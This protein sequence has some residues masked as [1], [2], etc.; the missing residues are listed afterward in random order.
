[1]EKNCESAKTITL[2]D[3]IDFLDIISDKIVGVTAMMAAVFSAAEEA[4]VKTI[5]SSVSES[6]V[7]VTMET[8]QPGFGQMV[9]ELRKRF[10]VM[11]YR[12][13]AQFS[14]VGEEFLH[15]C[16]GLASR[17]EKVLPGSVYLVCMSPVQ[18]SLS[19]V[20]DKEYAVDVVNHIHELMFPKES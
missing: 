6:R 4:G 2:K 19:Y 3:D 14:I 7:R 5:L 16:P 13:K 17:I 8:G 15:S 10:T 12:D 20:I 1:M 11:I 9:A 18:M